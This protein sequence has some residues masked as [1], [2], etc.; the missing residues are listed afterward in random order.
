MSRAQG[1]L[2]RLVD[3][4]RSRRSDA[5]IDDELRSHL[6]FHI[7]DN[8]RRGMTPEE[9]RRD[10]WM[11]LGGFE[12]SRD[13]YREQRG[14]PVIDSLTRDT[15]HALRL[16]RKSPGFSL[17]A[18]AILALGI[19]AN[20]AI[21]SVVNAIVLKPMPFA[22]ASRIVRIWHTPPQEQFP[23][24]RRFSV[25]P[26]NYLDWKAQSTAFDHVAV[27]GY[28]QANLTGRGEPD[29]L[30]GVGVSGEFFQVLHASPLVGRLLEPGD[31]DEA[32]AHVVVLSEHT[33]NSRFGGDR[34]VVGQPIRL[35]GDSY[36]VVGVLPDRLRYPLQADLWRPLAWNAE[37]RAIRGNHNY[38]VIAHLAPG[39]DLARAQGEL[40]TISKRLE[41]QYP[42][43][44]KGWGAVVVP[45]HDAVVGDVRVGLLVLL[46]A[47]ACVLLIACANL[48]NLMLARVLGRSR[49]IAIRSAVG[50]GRWRIVQQLLVES[51]VLAIAGA[52]VGL[53]AAA[54]SVD[55][56]VKSF[57]QSL[58]RAAE[59]TL[60]GQVVAFTAVLAIVTGVLAG[61]A[62]AWRMTRGDTAEALK[63]G[64]G[65][66][67][68]HSGERRVRNVLVTAEVALALMLLVGAGLLI[69][70]LW[71]L[72]AVN[73][74]F[75]PRNVVTMEISLPQPK[76]PKPEQREQF[77]VEMLR[78]VRALPG[79]QG[80]GTIDSLPVEDGGSMQPIAIVGEPVRPLSEQPE[81]AVR[82]ISPGYLDT[83]RMRVESGR[84]FTER[85]QADRPLTVLVSAATARRFWPQG[86][87]I[88]KRI[89]LGLISND[90][91][92]VVGVVNDVKVHGLSAADMQ[93]VYVPEAQVRFGFATLVVRAAGDPLGLVP[94]VTAAIHTIDA[95]Q[96]IVEVHT[97]DEI[98]G[99]SIAQQRFAMR[100]LTA[101][102]ALA[103]LLASIGIY[104]VLS[105]GVRQRVQEI[106]IRMALG[107]ARSDVVRMVVIEGLK[108]TLVGLAV[109][110]AGSAALGQVLSSLVFGVTP[111]DAATF[112]VV[113]TAVLAVGLLASLAPAYRATRV[114]PLLALRA[115]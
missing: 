29:A 105:Y 9:A 54:W 102:A 21:F 41:T 69:R 58:P 15:R 26:A 20:A 67:G 89:V 101:F 39:V 82:T 48:A 112:A 79:V 12:R 76:Y 115:D 46:G 35:N 80:A 47:V 53:T 14:F 25:S 51:S 100:L 62:P 50:A 37:E 68:S 103:L 109:G 74:G 104:G 23:G 99:E 19:G 60:D 78:R 85:D 88:G 55:A 110:L 43:D 5:E 97:M 7:E 72:R 61:V 49:E 87:P 44:D 17:T 45:L 59:V 1:W 2:A 38:A 90:P 13:E 6:E 27:F 11:A 86:S 4:L 111:R 93:A 56:I 18:I 66:G 28:R 3:P 106:G 95:E 114:D 92:E 57:G 73:P 108:P 32:H 40:T 63:Q 83:V 52:I 70:T 84:D 16:L 94:A 65:R 24:I 8:I 96:P 64:M 33:W 81:I 42:A 71:S 113:S 34:R 98:I 36:T 22:D 91:R 107:A 75:D 77:T 10:A 31:D 30:T